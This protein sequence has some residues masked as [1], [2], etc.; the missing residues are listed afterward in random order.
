MNLLEIKLQMCILKLHLLRF[1]QKMEKGKKGVTK[2]SKTMIVLQLV[3]VIGAVIIVILFAP[4][5]D[6]PLDG[7]VV[8]GNIVEF[9]FR[10]ANAILIDNNPE[11]NSPQ[12]VDFN[13]INSNKLRLNPG[14]YYWKA[15]GKME[16]E[17]KSFIINSNVGL[18]LNDKEEKIKNVGNVPAN[19]SKR[20]KDGVSGLAILDVEVEYPVDVEEK[21]NYKGEQYDK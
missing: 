6:S 2:L 18:E 19:V 17:I 3:I 7:A 20:D 12:L 14:T 10:N 11:F 16:S 8:D 9:R 13:E 4:K 5:I 21:V 1:K 15:V